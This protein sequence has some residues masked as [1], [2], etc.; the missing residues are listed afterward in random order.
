[1]ACCC[2]PRRHG[3]WRM[4][5]ARLPLQVVCHVNMFIPTNKLTA[6][7]YHV[8]RATHPRASCNNTT[9]IMQHIHV[10]HANNT[11]CIMQ[12]PARTSMGTPPA[13]PPGGSARPTS[14]A[15]GGGGAGGSCLA[16][17]ACLTSCLAAITCGVMGAVSR[18]SVLQQCRALQH[19]ATSR[20]SHRLWR[21]GVV[22]SSE[23]QQRCMRLL[24]VTAY[25][26]DTTDPNVKRLYTRVLPFLRACAYGQFGPSKGHTRYARAF[27]HAGHVHAYTY[28]HPHSCA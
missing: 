20:G 16:L 24:R 12:L 27:M 3:A 8:H 1:M 23:R 19:S 26:T 28:A 25:R 15:F 21:V 2:M 13:T 5:H 11:T 22:Y 14:A 4:Y 7:Q 9:C 6:Q 10:H 18:C 17:A